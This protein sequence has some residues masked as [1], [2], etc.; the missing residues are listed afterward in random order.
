[1]NSSVDVSIPDGSKAIPRFSEAIA[2]NSEMINVI[3]RLCSQ[4]GHTLICCAKSNNKGFHTFVRENMVWLEEGEH[5]TTTAQCIAAMQDLVGIVGGFKLRAY[6]S[7]SLPFQAMAARQ[8]DK[9]ALEKLRKSLEDLLKDQMNYL[10]EPSNDPLNSPGF[11]Q[12]NPFTC[13]HVFRALVQ[14]TH[15]SA[16]TSWKA[17]FGM[18]WA[19]GRKYPSYESSSGVSMP[20]S[21]PTAF[22][23]SR[24]IDA[25]ELMVD[26]LRRRWKR[27]N[28][29]I[30]LVETLK[31]LG[32][33]QVDQVKKQADAWIKHRRLALKAQISECLEEFTLDAALPELFERWN[34]E[35][36]NNTSEFD[37][38]TL[39]KTFS[40]AITPLADAMKNTASN[41]SGNLD[42]MKETYLNPITTIEEA[43]SSASLQQPK[44]RDANSAVNFDDA[45]KKLPRGLVDDGYRNSSVADRANQNDELSKYW[46]DHTIA[47]TA[48]LKTCGDLRIFL[49]QTIDEYSDDKKDLV[50]KLKSAVKGMDNQERKLRDFLRGPIASSE[51]VMYQQLAWARSAR[52]GDFDPAEL[53]HAARIAVRYGS[54]RNASAVLEA[55]GVI[56][57]TQ[58]PDGNWT[59]TQPFFWKSSGL[60]AYPHSAE[61]AWALVSIMRTLSESPE[62]YGLGPT[63]ALARLQVGDEALI[64]QSTKYDLS[65]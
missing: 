35:I 51:G 30:K 49:G 52:M 56:C 50:E 20:D 24:C 65:R 58:N 25:V 23:T 5:P 13:A 4:I 26:T 41:I 48:A 59:C 39:E 28:S 18:L 57:K 9:K 7:P 43:F 62:R 2:D 63:E 44:S 47:V 6:E 40:N 29:L 21:L 19:L 14:S 32:A 15:F 3:E 17:L 42:Y 34:I 38:N 36:K 61:V 46:L 33:E 45:L 16:S 8:L 11:G 54:P 64:N 37:F 53:A 12:L 31:G 60:A 55:V 10:V 27:M 1:M 22:G